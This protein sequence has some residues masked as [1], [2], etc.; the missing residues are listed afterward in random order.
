MH[1]PRPS[2][3]YIARYG[4]WGWDSEPWY[5]EEILTV[6]LGD[7]CPECH[8]GEMKLSKNNKLYCSEICWVDE[9]DDDA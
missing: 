6:H 3:D 8:V 2:R 9:E 5:D 1:D 7:K 4:G